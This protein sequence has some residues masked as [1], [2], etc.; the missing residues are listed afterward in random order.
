MQP[1]IS[2]TSSTWAPA[3]DLTVTYGPLPEHVINLRLP[4]V[5]PGPGR[6]RVAVV[7]DGPHWAGND[8]EMTSTIMLAVVKGGQIGGFGLGDCLVLVMWPVVLFRAL[9]SDAVPVVVHGSLVSS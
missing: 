9:G 4:A 3:P 6:G 8:A 2:K 5:T 1:V 7:R